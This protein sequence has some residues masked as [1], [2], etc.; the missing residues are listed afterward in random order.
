MP[1]NKILD[2]RTRGRADR[3]PDKSPQPRTHHQISTEQ[4]HR[5][6]RQVD[7]ANLTELL[8]P[9]RFQ[10]RA[11]ARHQVSS[12]MEDSRK[13]MAV[14]PKARVTT[15][16]RPAR[17]RVT[18][19]HRR[20][21]N[22]ASSSSSSSRVDTAALL[23]QPNTEHHPQDSINR[24]HRTSTVEDTEARLNKATAAL[25]QDSTVH[26]RV[27]SRVD[28]MVDRSKVAEGI[29]EVEM[30]LREDFQVRVMVLEATISQAGKYN[31]WQRA[32]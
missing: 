19:T 12:N 17:R 15:R 11:M 6:R 32:G 21:R 18:T 14:T 26:N 8:Q 3:T 24:L 30:A 9:S 2:T 10:A 28:S 4:Q 31:G 25:L 20:N 23:R 16:I 7:L 29:Q 27:A 22:T 5:V 1:R 13:I